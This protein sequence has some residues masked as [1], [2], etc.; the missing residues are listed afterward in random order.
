MKKIV[1]IIIIGIFIMPNSIIYAKSNMEYQ[2]TVY[3]AEDAIDEYW[4]VVVVALNE[5]EEPYFYN[6]LIESKNWDKNHI[7]LLWKENATKDKIL[8]SLLWLKENVDENDYVLFSFQGHGGCQNGEYGIGTWDHDFITTEEFD[9][10]FDTISYEGMCLIFSCCF[11]G[12]LVGYKTKHSEVFMKEKFQYEFPLGVEDNNRVVIMDTMKSGLGF[13]RFIRE[14]DGSLT[15]NCFHR[16]VS[17]AL[18]TKDDNNDGFC[19]AEEAFKHARKVLLPIALV[20]FIL[21]PI[22]IYLYI[23]E[24]YFV[25]PLPTISD[26]Y[27]GELPLTQL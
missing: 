26:N 21:I 27:P 7:L 10:N 15:E 3:P 11:S 6:T 4:G 9:N 22:Q 23:I 8:E 25:L 20:F 14:D 16:Y 18:K 19:S 13:V 5:S 1:S 12:N 2:G 24:G 17:D